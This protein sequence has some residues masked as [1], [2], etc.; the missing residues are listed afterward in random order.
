MATQRGRKAHSL[1]SSQLT[2]S[3]P[4]ALKT[5][6]CARAHTRL[7]SLSNDLLVMIFS[8]FKYNLKTY[9]WMVYVYA[10]DCQKEQRERRST[11]Y[12]LTLVSRRFN[13]LAS[14]VLYLACVPIEVT[15]RVGP[16][17]PRLAVFHRPLTPNTHQNLLC[18][19]RLSLAQ[20]ERWHN[21]SWN[22]LRTCLNVTH[23]ELSFDSLKFDVEGQVAITLSVL[24]HIKVAVLRF[25]YSVSLDGYR[26]GSKIIAHF[27]GL[28][29]L[30]AINL[31]DLHDVESY[32]PILKEKRLDVLALSRRGDPYIFKSLTRL[33]EIMQYTPHL[34][35]TGL[36]GWTADFEAFEHLPVTHLSLLN[37]AWGHNRVRL[38]STLRKL[39]IGHSDVPL[40]NLDMPINLETMELANMGL[41]DVCFVL[42]S[43]AVKRW[44]LPNLKSLSISGTVG[45]HK[46][47]YSWELSGLA[48]SMRSV[49][50][51]IVCLRRSGVVIVPGDLEGRLQRTFLQIQ[52]DSSY[53]L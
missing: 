23:I 20:V 46:R 16:K 17:Q 4:Y 10:G 27:A 9:S 40:E 34:V 53:L 43:I 15:Q 29:M 38:P 33:L 13:A 22:M 44:Q 18:I 21:P 49:H 6:L 37:Q 48:E 30:E 1:L 14:P 39:F 42:K 26:I 2:A 51:H 52:N 11:L 28:P 32:G 3:I 36:P 31:N 24:R 12:S 50:K 45:P 25:P 19:R 8:Q 5:A 47:P 35:F 7:S 41:V